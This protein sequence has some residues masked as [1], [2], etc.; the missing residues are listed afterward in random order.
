MSDTPTVRFY[1]W[2]KSAAIDA[3]TSVL[4]AADRVGISIESLCGG[5]GLCGT[6]KVIVD[7][8][9]EHLTPPTEADET[10]LSEDQLEDGYRLSCRA[11][12]AADATCSGSESTV[13]VTV[14]SVSQN[15]G[16]IVLTEGNELAFDLD[17]AVRKYHLELDEP[18]LEANTADLERLTAGLEAGYDLTVEDVD[19]LVHRE[20][21]TSL[22]GKTHDG[23]LE[24]TATVYNGAEIIDVQPGW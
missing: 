19:H 21:P 2:D 4:E 22:R 6:C 3:D 9:A 13:D 5:E 16:G 8:G 11:S 10:L 7:E 15:T 14:P 17:P 20:L 12:M 23:T 24:V 1:P 18:T